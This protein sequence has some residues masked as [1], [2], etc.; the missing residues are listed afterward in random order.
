MTLDAPLGRPRPA[1]P[2]HVRA[3]GRRGLARRAVGQA[4]RQD[5]RVRRDRARRDRGAQVLEFDGEHYQ[6]PYR[7]NGATGLGKPLKLMARPLRD[8]IPIY[9]ASLKPRSV[10]LAA[11]IADGW[12]P[13]F[14]SP[15]RARKTFPEPFARD[16]L[17]IAPA[18]PGDRRRRR[19][20]GPRHA[21]AVLRALHRRHGRA[22]L[23]LLQRPRLRVRL[24]GRGEADPGSLPRRQ[25][26]RRGGGGAR[27]ARGRDGAGRPA[28]RIGER[29]DG[30]E[31]VRCHRAAR[32][33]ARRSSTL[34]AIAELGA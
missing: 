24:R 18:V 5:A 33:D 6:V 11:E 9:L 32:L 19:R 27:R 17:E 22:G 31:G 25:A 16:G 28:E 7:G 29:L 2:R 1:R 21:Q 12:L 13:I 10:A 30:L 14:F 3:A 34:R 4:A 23:E 26:A 15:E 20:A 8:S